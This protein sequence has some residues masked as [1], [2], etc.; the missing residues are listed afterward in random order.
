[1]TAF[2]VTAWWTALPR[3]SLGM[4]VA[5]ALA[6]GAGLL[7]AAV[8]IIQCRRKRSS[9]AWTLT[10]ASLQDTCLG[11]LLATA[12]SRSPRAC[13][14]RW[15]WAPSQ[16]PPASSSPAGCAG[17][18]APAVVRLRLRRGVRLG[19]HR[20]APPADRQAPRWTHSR[21]AGRGSEGR[22][23]TAA[24]PV[25]RCVRTRRRSGHFHGHTHFS[26]PVR[27]RILVRTHT[28]R[29][30]AEGRRAPYHA[31]KAIDSHVP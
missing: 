11:V 24:E 3:L 1:M 23:V 8:V 25:R 28:G 2:A 17:C 14:W 20:R 7:A 4:V 27:T 18:T 15:C 9:P 13:S 12:L 30:P 26:A 6:G 19:E 21:A 5:Y 22:R 16:P 10:F 31:Q 29:E